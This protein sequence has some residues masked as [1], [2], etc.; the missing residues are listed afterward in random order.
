MGI[1]GSVGVG[2]GGSIG[3]G[4]AGS[5]GIDGGGSIG[6]EPAT[7]ERSVPSQ[8]SNRLTNVSLMLLLLTHRGG[9]V[10]HAMSRA[11]ELCVAFPAMRR[12]S[13][14]LQSMSQQSVHLRLGR[15]HRPSTPLRRASTVAPGLPS[16]G[17]LDDCQQRVNIMGA[18]DR[19]TGSEA[20][21]QKGG[22]GYVLL[23]LMGVPIPLLILFALLRGCA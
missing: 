17:W 21:K 8:P 13:A 11:R 3:M 15:R 14:S 9:S 1:G 2:G 16:P 12:R 18:T 5:I 4:G 22:I 6:V 10:H 19:A 20:G 23:W 7:V